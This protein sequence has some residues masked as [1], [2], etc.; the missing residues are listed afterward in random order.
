MRSARTRSEAATFTY[1]DVLGVS[2]SAPH[3]EVRDAYRRLARETHPD[4]VAASGDLDPD[5]AELLIRTV[6]EAWEVLGDPASRATYDAELARSRRDDPARWEAAV[7]DEDDE[8][9]PAERPSSVIAGLLPL[10]VLVAL[11]MVIVV[12]TAYARTS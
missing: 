1:Y 6:N 3:G 9:W 8:H 4:V 12:F 10:L 11:L 7:S 2:P 5:D